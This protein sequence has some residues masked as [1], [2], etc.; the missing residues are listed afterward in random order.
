MIEIVE[1]THTYRVGKETIRVL[2]IPSL[3]VGPGERV[4]VVGPSGSGKSTLIQIIAGLT[5]PTTGRVI[6]DGVDIGALGE[7][8]RDRLRARRMGLIFQALNLLGG[9]TALENILM[10]AKWSGI[11]NKFERLQAATALLHR[12]GL[13][14]RMH[15]DVRRLSHGEKQRVAIARALVHQPSIV[16]ADEPTASL[17]SVNKTVV[18]DELLALVREK[19]ATLVFVTHDT[20]LLSAF[21]RVLTLGPGGVVSDR[22]PVPGE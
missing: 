22:S 20:T 8:Q 6:I 16:L 18:L 12:L 10:A 17:D 13:N 19:G 4:A 1:V 14:D 15:V 11:K 5:L 21:T 2:E 9:F 3:V 7:S